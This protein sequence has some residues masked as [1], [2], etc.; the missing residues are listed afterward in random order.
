MNGDQLKNSSLVPGFNFSIGVYGECIS[1]ERI[2]LNGNPFGR[3]LF[4]SE[5]RTDRVSFPED[6]LSALEEGASLNTRVTVSAQAVEPRSKME[7]VSGMMCSKDRAE[8]SFEC[9]DNDSEKDEQCG[10]DPQGLSLSGFALQEIGKA[11]DARGSR[12]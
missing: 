12:F 6:V 11:A 5:Y 4:G 8:N 2:Q 3:I 10:E 1:G 9:V 7:R